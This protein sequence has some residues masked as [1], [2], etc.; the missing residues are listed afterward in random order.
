MLIIVMAKFHLTF[1]FHFFRDVA[2]PRDGERVALKKIPN[3]FH[4]TVSSKRIYR[5]L[6]I[7]T[8]LNHDNVSEAI[9]ICSRTCNESES[10]ASGSL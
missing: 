3:I 2:D 4:N 9:I 6:K 1:H 7:L 8:H 10:V 5:E